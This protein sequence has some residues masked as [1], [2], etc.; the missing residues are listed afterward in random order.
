MPFEAYIGYL[1]DKDEAISAGESI[2]I[3]VRDMDTY[4]RKVVRAMIGKPGDSLDESDDLWVLDWVEARQEEPW[5]IRVLEELDED[6]E[7]A[8]RSDISP[9]DLR[10]P[11][12]D[13]ESFA[14]GRGRGNSMPGMMGA[15]EARKYFEN[16][17]GKKT[18][19]RK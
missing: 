14:S 3:E 12:E 7:A 19:P 11:A 15:E 13:S 16:V 9:E 4:E 8:V 18:G 10:K 1:D 6:D 17:V 2:V 5:R